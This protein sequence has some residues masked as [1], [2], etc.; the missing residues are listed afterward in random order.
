MHHKTFESGELIFREGDDSNEAYWIL[1][2]KVEISIGT[3]QGR[4]ILTTLDRGEIFGE[5]GL[6]DDRPRAAT[7]RALG[8]SDHEGSSALFRANLTLEDHRPYSVSRGHCM[9]E[10]KGG[11]FFVLDCGSRLGTTV[12]GKQLGGG[13]REIVAELRTGSNTLLLGLQEGPQNYLINVG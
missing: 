12:N 11:K 9:I 8:R 7:A 13:T 5:M 1:S 6:V 3:P 2:G 4:S 10:S